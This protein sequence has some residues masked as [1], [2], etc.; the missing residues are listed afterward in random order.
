MAVE[1]EGQEDGRCMDRHHKLP[2]GTDSIPK[3]NHVATRLSY[4]SFE[5]ITE[6]INVNCIKDDQLF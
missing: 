3:V 6:V 1:N 4:D 2:G 5:Y